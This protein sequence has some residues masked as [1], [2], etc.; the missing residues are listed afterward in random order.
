LCIVIPGEAEG[1]EPGIHNPRPVVMDSGF[2]PFGA[3]R[4]DSSVQRGTPAFLLIGD[5]KILVERRGIFDQ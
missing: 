5:A 3:P 1:R 4:N 2:A